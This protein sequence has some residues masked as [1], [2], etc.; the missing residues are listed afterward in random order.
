MWDWEEQ[1]LKGLWASEVGTAFPEMKGVLAS[2]HL[3]SFL[4]VQ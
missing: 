4:F 1:R 3:L 2:G